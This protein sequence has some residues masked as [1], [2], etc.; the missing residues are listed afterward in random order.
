MKIKLI[1]LS[2]FSCALFLNIISGQSQ[3]IIKTGFG[4]GLLID[5]EG[6]GDRELYY[7]PKPMHFGPN[8]GLEFRFRTQKVM[9]PLI[10]F[11][12]VRHAFQYGDYFGG[13]GGG[14]GFDGNFQ[15]IHGYSVFGAII[16]CNNSLNLRFGMGAMK[17]LLAKTNAIEQ[18]Y[19]FYATH[20]QTKVHI[21][22]F[23]S[24]SFPI[25]VFGLELP[26]HGFSV[27]FTIMHEIH[28]KFVEQG[29]HDGFQPQIA[30]W[31]IEV[32]YP[33]HQHSRLK[34]QKS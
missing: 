34:D 18:E 30:T 17:Q 12:L 9:Q 24:T 22:D 5:Y 3:I 19:G 2:F 1:F 14:V 6:I 33:I 8:F 31:R 27:A 20:Q 16:K 7:K 11:G 25:G 13:L 15:F 4:S 29:S 26:F 10:E 28:T 21:S 32:L 23:F